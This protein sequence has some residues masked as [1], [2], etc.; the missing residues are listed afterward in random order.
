M[1]HSAVFSASQRAVAL[2][3]AVVSMAT[4]TSGAESMTL[5]L[6]ARQPVMRSLV[7][8]YRPV[9]I[10]L[11]GRP[12][13]ELK[14]EP[15]YIS[16]TPLYGAMKLGSGADALVTIVID[17]VDNQSERIYVDRNNDEDLT[18]DG[19]GPWNADSR[20]SLRLSNVEIQVPYE[21][22]PVPYTFEFYRFRTRLRE[23]VFYYRNAAREG[24]ITSDGKAYEIAVLDENADGRFDDLVNGTILIDLNQDGQLAGRS[25]SA[26]HHKLNEPFNIHGQVWEVTSVSPDGT[27]MTVRPS[28]ADVAMKPDLGRG[29]PAPLFEAKGLDGE[30]ICLKD[31]AS[32]DGY[33]LLDFWASWCA[34]CRKEFPMLRDLHARYKGKGLQIIGVNLDSQLDK[35]VE[36]ARQESLDYPHVFDGRGWQSAV[37]Q[38]YRVHSIPQAYLLDKDLRIVA[39]RLRGPALER[40]LESLLG[41]KTGETRSAPG[42]TR[43][44]SDSS[45]G[46]KSQVGIS[47]ELADEVQARYDAVGHAELRQVALAEAQ[48]DGSN[49]D[50]NRL[51]PGAVVVIRTDQGRYT[52]CLIE[53]YGYDLTVSWITYDEEGGVH[54]QGVHLRINGMGTCDFDAGEQDSQAADVWWRQVTEVDRYLVPR[55]GAR[56][57]IVFS[58]TR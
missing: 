3:L 28:Q 47:P 19:S 26:E 25:D 5:E 35:A 29:H 53:E 15:E 2:A 38:L 17:E 49:N 58:P 46:E 21:T 57:G 45:A 9:R 4:W 24:S 37:A 31:Y 41:S 36:M 40:S 55:N 10:A 30:R 43:S 20:S 34:P 52:K 33:I 54:S 12:A 39:A 18:N 42:A 50:R 1:F 22:G 6:S 48:V 14:A 13:E 7:N 23:F 16:A 8:Y 11:S 56:L 44:V 27:T 32:E 51:Y